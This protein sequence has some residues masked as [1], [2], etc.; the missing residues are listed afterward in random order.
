MNKTRIIKDFGLHYEKI[1]TC[2]NEFRFFPYNLPP[3][4]C[5]KKPYTF[6]SLLIPG[7][8]GLR[9]DIDEKL[10]AKKASAQDQGFETD[11]L[12]IYREVVGKASHDCVLSMGS[13]IKAKDVYG[14]CEGSCKRARI[15]N[16]EEELQ[17]YKAMKD[18]FKQL[19]ATQEVKQMREF[20][21]HYAV[22][23]RFIFDG[24][25]K[26]RYLR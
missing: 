7:L 18:E 11:E 6:M 1:D 16:M 25:S 22:D 15:K 13:S 26:I 24:R 21:K 4:M 3:W 12:N 8:K 20:I 14:Y 5:M 19:K 23:N 9:N 2:D 17:Q 10:E